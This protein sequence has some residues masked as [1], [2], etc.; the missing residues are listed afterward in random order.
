MK[1]TCAKCQGEG[2]IEIPCNECDGSGHAETSFSNFEIP[3]DHVRAE[4]LRSLKRDFSSVV[5]ATEILKKMNP[6]HA[7]SY[8]RQ[9]EQ[10]VEKIETEAEAELKM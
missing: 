4:E 2:V 10:A 5:R 7:D 8:Q 1:C 6:Q 3:R 9:M